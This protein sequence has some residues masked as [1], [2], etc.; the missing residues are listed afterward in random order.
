V[1]Q[2]ELS[3]R[4]PQPAV[5]EGWADNRTAHPVVVR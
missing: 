3:T 4:A 2:L 5:P 1:Q